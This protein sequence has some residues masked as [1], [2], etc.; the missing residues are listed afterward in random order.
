MEAV[1]DLVEDQVLRVESV[2]PPPPEE[3][4]EPSL[5]ELLF[6]DV[7]PQDFLLGEERSVF[8]LDY[9]GRMFPVWIH[10]P[11]EKDLA[12]L[13][14]ALRYFFNRLDGE[15][16]LRA[17]V[18]EDRDTRRQQLEL[19]FTEVRR[20][21]VVLFPLRLSALHRRV[22]PGSSLSTWWLRPEVWESR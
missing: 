3:G 17:L 18:A 20:R 19:L 15:A 6:E 4:P 5:Y 1:V 9:F 10:K 12:R 21:N 2:A 8:S 22:D 14:P 13:S 11:R 16:P 7:A